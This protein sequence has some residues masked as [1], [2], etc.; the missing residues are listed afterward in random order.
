MQNPVERPCPECGGQRAV[1]PSSRD[2]TY[3]IPTEVYDKRFLAVICTNCGYTSFYAQ[4]LDK[5]AR[6]FAK[7]PAAVQKG[8]QE[9]AQRL[10]ESQNWRDKQ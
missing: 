5:L 7:N 6:A 9:N 8:L 3:T 1:F 10:A 4:E 2:V